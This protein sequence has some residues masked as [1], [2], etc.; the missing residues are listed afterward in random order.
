MSFRDGQ[1]LT[2]RLH[3]VRDDEQ[4]EPSQR[5]EETAPLRGVRSLSEFFA[6]KLN[7]KRADPVDVG[8][9]LPLG[10]PSR[11]RPEA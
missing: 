1:P 4:A 11:S 9:H 8:Y 6:R 5:T 2:E 10:S 3:F 7:G